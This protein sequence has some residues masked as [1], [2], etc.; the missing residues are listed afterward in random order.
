MTIRSGDAPMIASLFHV[1]AVP[2]FGMFAASGIVRNTASP[3]TPSRPKKP[4][5]IFSGGHTEVEHRRHGADMG[6]DHSLRIRR[7]LDTARLILHC[8]ETTWRRAVFVAAAR[9]QQ[10][11]GR[12]TEP[13]AEETP[14]RQRID[15][16]SPLLVCIECGVIECGHQADRVRHSSVHSFERSRITS[17][18]AIEP[19]KLN[20]ISSRQL[21]LSGHTFLTTLDFNCIGPM[22]STLQSMS[23][24]PTP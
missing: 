7:N 21:S 10:C 15:D 3:L 18:V 22:P 23:W 13:G 24:S 4:P 14:A 8:D 6:D 12:D 2:R 16:A 1:P 17:I 20:R 5:T 11:R 19:S 9:C